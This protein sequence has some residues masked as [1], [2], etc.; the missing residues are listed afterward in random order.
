MPPEAAEATNQQGQQAA[1]QDAGQQGQSQA[2]AGQADAAGQGQQAQA[3]KPPEGLDAAY[4]DEKAGAIKFDALKADLT[5]LQ[6]LR[7]FKAEADIRAQGVPKD[8]KDYK[9]EAGDFQMPDGME[10]AMPADDDPFVGEV[11]SIL[12][13]AGAPQEVMTKLVAAKLRADIAM[14]DKWNQDMAAQRALLGDKAADRIAAVETA[15]VGRL[16]DKGKALTGLLVSANVV[17]A[18]EGLL[19]TTTA[20]GPGATQNNGKPAIPNFNPNG[21]PA[22]KFA[23][24]YAANSGS[25]SRAAKGN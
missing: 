7:T 5:A 12:H 23:A 10:I 3:S 4:W 8:P 15:L 11:K 16:G 6:E 24:I 1:A 2:A 19:R 17:E 21:S 22:A 13:S 25:Q 14:A 18:F 20:P 9:I